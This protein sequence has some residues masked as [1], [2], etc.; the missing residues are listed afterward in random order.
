MAENFEKQVLRLA[1]SDTEDV[2]WLKG[3]G[4]EISFSAIRGL[5]RMSDLLALQPNL[6]IIFI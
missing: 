4:L 2:P 5:L 1:A 3:S 6:D